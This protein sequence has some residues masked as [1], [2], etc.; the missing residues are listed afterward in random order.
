MPVVKFHSFP[1]EL[2]PMIIVNPDD[3]EFTNTFFRIAL[4]LGGYDHKVFAVF[5][6][7]LEEALELLGAYCD[8]HHKGFIVDASELSEEEL[9]SR[10]FVFVNGALDC[11]LETTELMRDMVEEYQLSVVFT[12]V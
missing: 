3:S 7:H 10:S 1:I 11:A 2:C 6:N 12:K 4:P 9:E 5:A 8:D